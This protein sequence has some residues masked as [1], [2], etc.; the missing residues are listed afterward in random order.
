M[1]KLCS[2]DW[3][4]NLWEVENLALRISLAPQADQVVDD[5]LEQE[6]RCALS[7]SAVSSGSHQAEAVKPLKEALRDFE[8]QYIRHVVSQS[9]SLQ[10]AARSLGIGYSTLCRKRAEYGMTE[11]AGAFPRFPEKP[12]PAFQIP[13]AADIFHGFFPCIP[14]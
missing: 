10:S 7:P 6:K 1:Q 14:P 4:G 5:Y 12:A 8:I 3:A 11:R 2:L 9:G 13:L